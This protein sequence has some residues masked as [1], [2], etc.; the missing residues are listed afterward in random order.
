MQNFCR[1]IFHL[2]GT[3]SISRIAFLTSQNRIKFFDLYSSIYGMLFDVIV[4]HII[5]VIIANELIQPYRVQAY[6][7]VLTMAYCQMNE[8]AMFDVVSVSLDC[9]ILFGCCRGCFFDKKLMF[10]LNFICLLIIILSFHFLISV[11]LQ[12]IYVAMLIDYFF[13]NVFIFQI[14]LS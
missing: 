11:G 12:M 6:M 1:K 5:L 8:N 13:I 3:S 10:S 7:F 9:Y 2:F 14:L 4:K